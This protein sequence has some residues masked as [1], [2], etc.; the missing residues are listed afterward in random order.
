MKELAVKTLLERGITLPEIAEI[1]LDLQKPYIPHLTVEECLL[2]VERIVEKREVINAIITGVALDKLTEQGHIEEPLNTILKTDDGL[3]GID[4]I[5]A[6]SIVNIYGTIGLTN[7]GY[8]DKTKPGIIAELN[9][10]SNTQVNTF[11]DDIVCAIAAASASRIA[12]RDRDLAE[13]KELSQSS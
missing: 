12:H 8:L 4:E 1:V 11:L 2:S 13:A 10:K 9:N 3:Y 5:L 6:L 7:F